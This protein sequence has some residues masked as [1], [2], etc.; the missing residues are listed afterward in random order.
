VDPAVFDLFE[1]W[2][3]TQKLPQ[4]PGLLP[5]SEGW[6][7][8]LMVKCLHFSVQYRA[9]AFDE[10][11]NSVFVDTVFT[12]GLNPYYST[13][14]YAYKHISDM[15]H[16]L[17]RLLVDYHCE[18]YGLDGCVSINDSVARDIPVPFW[19]NMMERYAGM[20]NMV[21]AED[22]LAQDVIIYMPRGRTGRLVRFV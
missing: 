12:T 20:K 13:I 1:D 19:R 3:Y 2:I 6:D 21:V 18:T 7:C 8:L 17:M 16:P 9:E 11:I 4:L 14:I 22:T 5:P 10:A 15:K